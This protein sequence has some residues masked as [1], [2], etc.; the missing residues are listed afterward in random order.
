VPPAELLIQKKMDAEGTVKALEASIALAENVDDF[1]TAK[2]LE[3]YSQ[4]VL[5][6]GLKNAQLFGVLRV[7]VT[8]QQISPPTFETMEIL[9]KA[10][11]IRRIK[12]AIDAVKA[13]V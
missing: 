8:G 4:L 11:S 1:S 5:D 3:A 13:T 2:L 7:A 10:E 12:L 6:L 9:G